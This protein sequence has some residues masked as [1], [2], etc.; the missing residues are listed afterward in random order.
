MKLLG[1]IG[2]PLSH[3]FSKK[4]FTQK[5]EQEGLAQD[6]QYE[7]FPIET[8]DKIVTLIQ[9][10]SSGSPESPS[11]LTLVGLNVTI[12]Y[13]EAVIPYV[14]ILDK[15]AKEIGAV[16]CI[17]IVEG[18]KIGFNTDYYGFQKS[19]L[20]L[21]GS[22]YQDKSLKALIL[23][24]GGS[25]KAVAYALQDLGI[26]YQYV[27]RSKQDNGL[28]YG[29]LDAEIIGSHKLIINTTPLGMTP[30][31]EGCPPISYDSL[32]SDYYLYD[33]V[34]NPETTT[35]MKKGFERGAKV[36]SGLD[37]LYFQAEK[38]WEIWNTPTNL[39]QS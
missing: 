6:W 2:Y 23:G 17:K 37:M 5:F 16:N 24:T 26:P 12:P 3:S 21:I 1:L 15:T 20:G 33:L 9:K 22:T 28:T 4:Y 10:Y 39:S 18:K 19:L 14:D 25:A 7:L 11:H 30:H 34:Y 27:S 32:D 8:I 29:Q 13:K 38:G 35:F 31:T 36:K